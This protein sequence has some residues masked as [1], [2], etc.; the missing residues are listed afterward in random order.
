[1]A[2]VADPTLEVIPDF[3][4]NAYAGIRADLQAATN[5]TEEEVVTRLSDT[6]NADHNARIA[7]WNQD[8]EAEARVLAEA[9]RARITQEDA[10]RAQR[11]AEAEKERL[12]AEKKKPKMNGF[13]EASSVGDYLTPRPAQYAIQKLT[14]FEYVELWY[15]SPEGCRDALKSSRSIAENDLSITRTDDQLTLRPTSAFKASKA[16]IADHELSF[17]IFLRAKNLFLV[18]IS[19]A[20]WPRPHIDAL[21]LFFWHL[22]NHSI[23]NNSDIGDMVILTY[24]SRVRQDWHDRLKRDEGF[25]IGNV[26]ENLIRMIN[27]ELWDKVRSRTLNVVRP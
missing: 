14:N 10:E 9:E 19:K 2:L 12:E 24:A 20:K 16:A 23:R 22:E 27:E 6:W 17:S 1:M 25:N 11:E 5:Q 4:G 15:F 21:S 7:E 8:Q 26:N 3:A 18:Q 13:D